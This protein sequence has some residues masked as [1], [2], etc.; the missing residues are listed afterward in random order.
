M[1]YLV[2]QALSSAFGTPPKQKQKQKNN[3]KNKKQ[4]NKKQQP[5]TK[6]K[7]KT[8]KTEISSE[9]VLNYYVAA[10]ISSGLF[11]SLYKNSLMQ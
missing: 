11:V 8:T 7:T 1:N 2:P 4:K 6:Q 9:A 5:K 3:D 10:S